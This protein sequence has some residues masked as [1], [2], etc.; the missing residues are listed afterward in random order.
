M[1]LVAFVVLEIVA[2]VVTDIEL[3]KALRLAHMAI[4]TFVCFAETAG[5]IYF[6]LLVIRVRAVSR[7]LLTCLY[8]QCLGWWWKRQDG[9]DHE[10]ACG[11]RR[12]IRLAS[13][14]QPSNLD[15]IRVEFAAS[16]NGIVL[17]SSA[18]LRAFPGRESIGSAVSVQRLREH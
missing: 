5:F 12:R 9:E 15:T 7:W 8:D 16:Y 6:G 11:V 13:C 18:H 3:S 4:F 17:S 1:L 14:R 10:S 2:L